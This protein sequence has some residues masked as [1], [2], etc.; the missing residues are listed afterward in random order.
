MKLASSHFQHVASPLWLRGFHPLSW[1][2][3]EGWSV[4]ISL[5]AEWGSPPP[6]LF[7]FLG[8]GSLSTCGGLE[9]FPVCPQSRGFKFPNPHPSHQRNGLPE[10]PLKP[11]HQKRDSWNPAGA[12]REELAPQE[13]P[14]SLSPHHGL[15]RLRLPSGGGKPVGGLAGK[16]DVQ[17][18]CV[19]RLPFFFFGPFC[20]DVRTSTFAN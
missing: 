13:G 6:F 1:I 18:V 4:D 7:V 17:R 15:L 9:W 2:L 20:L 16:G 10:S 3:G 5:N 14:G 12:E 19:S 11:S 8:K